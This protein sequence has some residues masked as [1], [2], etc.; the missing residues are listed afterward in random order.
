MAA[1]RLDADGAHML[2]PLDDAEHGRRA[3]PP[4]AS[5]AAR[6]SQ[7]WLLSLPMLG[8]RI[9][10]ACA[11]RRQAPWSAGDAPPAARRGA[12]QHTDRSSAAGDGT[13]MPRAR[14]ACI[15][16]SRQEGQA[17]R[18]RSPAASNAFCQ[19]SGSKPAERTQPELLL[20]LD[21]MALPVPFR[22]EVFVDAVRKNLDLI[23]NKC[24][25]RGRRSLAGAQRSAGKR[26]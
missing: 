13:T 16:S 7:L 22:R 25:Q 24:Q 9:E 4:P 11:V 21:C 5:A 19:L 10:A 23:C 12:D 15:T 17:D 8:Q 1:P 26:R 14:H 6:S 2:Q 3:W 18:S 20:A